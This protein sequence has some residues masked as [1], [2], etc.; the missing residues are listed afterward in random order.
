M[1]YD[2]A[3]ILKN[4]IRDQIDLGNIQY[5]ETLAG[6]VQTETA[7]KQ[8][9][10][11]ELIERSF[12]VYCPQTE[13]CDPNNIEPL[14]PDKDKKS[15]FYFERRGDILYTGREKGFNNFTAQLDL[16]GWLNPKKLGS[17]ECS[18]QAPIVAEM[19]RLLNRKAFN[20]PGGVYSKMSISPFSLKSKEPV[21]FSKYKYSDKFYN[22]LEYP[23]DYFSITFSVSFSLHDNCIDE[24]LISPEEPC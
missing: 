2:I 12:P 4:I 11:S 24:F 5:I 15:L 16:V 18:I 10:K 7:Q 22:L 23:Y 17:N 6:L 14:V 8:K 19:V 21:I 1:I 20:D 9:S 13:P 3:E